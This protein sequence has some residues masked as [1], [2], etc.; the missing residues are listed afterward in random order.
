MPTDSRRASGPENTLQY[1][2]YSKNKK[3]YEDFVKDLVNKNNKRKD[4]RKQ[5]ESRK[6]FLKTGIVSQ[7]KGSAYIELQNTKVICSAFDP[8][9]IPNRSEF[10]I[11][12]ELFCE[13]KFA[14]FSCKRRRNFQRDAEE[15]ELSISLK[16]ALEPAVVRHEFPNFQVDIYALVLQNDGSALAAAITCAGLALADANIPMY[17]LVT[18]SS[19]AIH[20]NIK[21]I[22]P[23]I[24]EES[25]CDTVAL[26]SVENGPKERGLATLAY[27]GN[28]NQVTILLQSGVMAVETL[29]QMTDNLTSECLRI[30]PLVQRCLVEKVMKNISNI[31]NLSTEQIIIP[32]TPEEPSA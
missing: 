31:P 16:R 30:Y 15:K 24:E 10:S 19:L 6:I 21:L 12:G 9:E 3:A 32:E 26:P 25:I 18:A 4:N 27:M 17:D 20:G 22:D 11:N 29:I 2:L 5:N 14:T 13:L 7:A 28:L 23:T 8:R 1:Y